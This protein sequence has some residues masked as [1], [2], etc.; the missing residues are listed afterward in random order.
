MA[1]ILHFTEQERN[2]GFDVEMWVKDGY[3]AAEVITNPADVEDE[4]QQLLRDTKLH[5]ALEVA[6]AH[7][8]QYRGVRLV[9]VYNLLGR[10]L[11]GCHWEYAPSEMFIE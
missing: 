5:V 3:V 6:K 11:F 7:S 10:R 2:T 9:T 8:K 1:E 4:Y